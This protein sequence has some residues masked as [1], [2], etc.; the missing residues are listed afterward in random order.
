MSNEP[1]A[2]IERAID[3]RA[4]ADFLDISVKTLQGWRQKRTGPRFYKIGNRV[5]YLPA[6][7]HNY[8]TTC[9][10]EPRSARDEAR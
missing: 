4:A 6:D 8:L 10:V 2:V 1:R 3:E 7:L 5:K 9:L